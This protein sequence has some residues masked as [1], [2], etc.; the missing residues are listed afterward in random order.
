MMSLATVPTVR[1]TVPNLHSTAAMWPIVDR[2]PALNGK[3]GSSHMRPDGTGV[4]TFRFTEAADA[5]ACARA[6]RDAGVFA[7][8]ELE[9]VGVLAAE[10]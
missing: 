2:V 7:S 1:A 10:W 8:V 6:C 5:V 3:S 9:G 4:A